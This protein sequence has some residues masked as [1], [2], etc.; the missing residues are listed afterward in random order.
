M[1]VDHYNVWALAIVVIVKRGNKSTLV[2]TGLGLC[3]RGRHTLTFGS[4]TFY[5]IMPKR[6]SKRKKVVT[7]LEDVAVSVDVEAGWLDKF[8]E[9]SGDDLAKLL[10]EIANLG[11]IK[12]VAI[13]KAR[14]NLPSFSG[15]KWIDFAENFGLHDTLENNQFEQVVTP[16][17]CL[18]PSVHE[19][20]FEAAW[21]TQDVYRERQQQRREAA[22][23]RI[24]DPV[25]HK[26]IYY[27]F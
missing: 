12:T 21:H 25:C 4:F 2:C 26:V 1:I 17:Y 16:A 8:L 5:L 3:F 18:P 13:K 22:R 11:K 14:T 10:G 7:R 6:A 23:V 24:M 19:I 20:M 15:A 27:A 9:L